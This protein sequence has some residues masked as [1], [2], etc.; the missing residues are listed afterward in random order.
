MPQRPV[1][2][3]AGAVARPGRL[4]V[5]VIG[6]L[7]VGAGLTGCGSD[8]VAI[9]GPPPQQ[10]DRSACRELVNGLPDA[11]ADQERRKVE[12]TDAAAAAWGDPAIVL[13][14]G[15]PAPDGFDEASACTTVNDVDWYIPQ[16]QLDANGESDLT[17]TTVNRE[18]YVE[19]RLPADYWPPATALADLSAAVSNNIEPTGR[20][21]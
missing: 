6:C 18:Q 7:L 4:T 13:V 12:P 3:N 14:C 19:V 1:P 9:E 21:S 17:M 5:G 20:C 10:G 8:T 16:E 15:V 2:A 11:V